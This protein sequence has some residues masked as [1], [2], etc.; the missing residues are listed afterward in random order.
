MEQKFKDDDT[1]IY[2]WWKGIV[3]DVVDSRRENP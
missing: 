1:G 3:V 2:S